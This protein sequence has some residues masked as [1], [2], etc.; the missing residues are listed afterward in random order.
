MEE[1]RAREQVRHRHMVGA[2]KYHIRIKH[3]VYLL[4]LLL[5]ITFTFLSRKRFICTK[6]KNLLTQEM[7]RIFKISSLLFMIS[8]L[9]LITKTLMYLNESLKWPSLNLT[10]IKRYTFGHYTVGCSIIKLFCKLSLD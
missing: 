2:Y 6:T 3:V 7:K 9:Y 8:S 10:V 4:F 5:T 1:R